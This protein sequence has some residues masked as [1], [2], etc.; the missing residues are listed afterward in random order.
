MLLRPF[1][2]PFERGREGD[3]SQ[4]GEQGDAQQNKGVRQPSAL[5]F[6]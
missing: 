4:Y 1:R 5:D 6:F 2:S 3:G